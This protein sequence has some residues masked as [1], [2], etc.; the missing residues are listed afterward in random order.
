[1]WIACRLFSD[2]VARRLRLEGVEAETAG[3]MV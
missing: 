3:D 2:G 1:M